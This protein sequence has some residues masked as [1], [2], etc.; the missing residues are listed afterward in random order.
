MAMIFRMAGFSLSARL[1]GRVVCGSQV[2]DA[3]L[4]RRHIDLP[5]PVYRPAIFQPMGM[6]RIAE[7]VAGLE[8]RSDKSWAPVSWVGASS[9][10][11]C[12]LAGTRTSITAVFGSCCSRPP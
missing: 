7:L 5:G 2:D 10:Q 12:A 8:R 11:I 9:N 1:R 6:N 3:A 4:V